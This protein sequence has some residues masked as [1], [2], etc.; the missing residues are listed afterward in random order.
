MKYFL[1]FVS[2]SYLLI[3]SL[4]AHAQLSVNFQTNASVTGTKI[5]L[6]DVAIIQPPGYEADQIGKLPVGI[7]PS[8]GTTKELSSAS[9]ITYLRYR[10][11]LTKVDWQGSETIL[12]QCLS[13]RVSQD[14]IKQIITD[15][16]KENSA[17]LPKTEIRF[18]STRSPDDLTFP[19]GKMSWKVTPSNP[20]IMG[21]S[22]FSISFSVNGKTTGTCVVHGKLEALADVVTAEITLQKGDLITK[23]NISLK[24]QN[25]D[26]LHK[27]FQ[28]IEQ[29]IG[30]QVART[31]NAG[32]AIEQ[33]FI[34][35]PPIIKD[36]DLVKIIARKGELQITTEGV[37][38]A[39]GRLGETIRVKNTNSN[40]LIYTRVD[41]PGIVSVEF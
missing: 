15:Y 35:S 19:S 18:T 36:G 25:L 2:L 38:K 6:A 3:F 12:V 9:I 1:S 29:L 22:S 31:I 41:G 4:E 30:M 7:A 14:Q 16:L 37:A 27:P 8:P 24:Q 23:D 13:N 10:P 40:N 21:S 32:R 33:K 34:V 11:E 39:E 5:T 20:E 26:G 28:S 17:K